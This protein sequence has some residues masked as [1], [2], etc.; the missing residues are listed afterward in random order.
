MKYEF[1]IGD[2]V[3]HKEE[4]VTGTIVELTSLKEVTEGDCKKDYP[5]YVIEW[6]EEDFTGQ[7]SEDSLLKI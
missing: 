3:I 1:Q 6:D 7:E 5:W 4:H 2:K